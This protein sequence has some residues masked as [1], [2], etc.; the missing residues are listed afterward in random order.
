VADILLK[1][2]AAII[3]R[4][5]PSRCVVLSSKW[6]RHKARRELLEAEIS[7]HIGSKFVF[8]GWTT[9]L[10]D[11]CTP[12]S[13]IRLIG[14]FVQG[15]SSWRYRRGSSRGL[16]ALIL[17]D[18]HINSFGWECDGL[19][20]DSAASAERYIESRV[21]GAIPISAKVV[22]TYAEWMTEGNLHVQVGTGLTLEHVCEAMKFLS[23]RACEVCRRAQQ[24]SLSKGVEM[25]VRD[26]TLKK[27]PRYVAEE[28]CLQGNDGEE[29]CR[30]VAV[31]RREA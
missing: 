12:E 3:Q 8:D 9:P 31:A 17:E 10:Q 30:P 25:K 20:I 15:L 29:I 1:R 23:G 13:R 27:R 18:F 5:G 28:N 7:K 6:R 24:C 16:R 4:A 2:L 14:N 26:N 11:P 22:H 21:E 19:H